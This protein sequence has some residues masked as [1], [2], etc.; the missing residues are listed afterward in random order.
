MTWRERAGRNSAAHSATH[1]FGIADFTV[2]PYGLRFVPRARHGPEPPYGLPS[3]L[4][5]AA[6]RLVNSGDIYQTRLCPW[7]DRSLIYL[8]YGDGRPS[9]RFGSQFA[10]APICSGTRVG[11][12]REIGPR[13]LGPEIARQCG[14][15]VGQ[16]GPFGKPDGLFLLLLLVLLLLLA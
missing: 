8:S 3:W 14:A 10:T 7:A 2:V 9:R 16:E 11:H 13:C 15:A 1:I 4:A 5:A 12:G 6:F